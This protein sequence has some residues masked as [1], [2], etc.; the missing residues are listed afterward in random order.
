VNINKIQT[1]G[2]TVLEDITAVI[3]TSSVLIFGD[4][5]QVA[6]LHF[7]LSGS[8]VD[9]GYYSCEFPSNSNLM[10]RVHRTSYSPV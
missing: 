3:D 8:S 1:Y 10:F 7:V 4:K 9:K 6:D 5:S 2:E